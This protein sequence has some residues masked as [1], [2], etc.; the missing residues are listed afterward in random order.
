MP[1]MLHPSKL[2]SL[3]IIRFPPG[4]IDYNNSDGAFW[5]SKA[6]LASEAA[7]KEKKMAHLL[8]S[9]AR[10][11]AHPLPGFKWSQSS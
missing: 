9:L 5:N 4:K 7:K 3:R 6:C 10:E 2:I 8:A 1:F 11:K